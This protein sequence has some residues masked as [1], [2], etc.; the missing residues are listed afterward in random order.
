MDDYKKDDIF[1]PG[2]LTNSEYKLEKY[3][4]RG[5]YGTVWKCINI[6]SNNIYAI[7]I[8]EK[9]DNFEDM[10]VIYKELCLLFAMKNSDNIVSFEDY[11]IIENTIFIIFEY[12]KYDLYSI[13]NFSKLTIDLIVKI[14]YKI[15]Q[16]LDYLHNNNLIHRDIKP[17]NILIS[18]NYNNCKLCDFGLTILNYNNL[19]GHHVVTRW[20]RAPEIILKCN[21]DYAIDIWATGCILAE[22]LI[23]LI[24]YDNDKI[25]DEQNSSKFVLFPGEYDTLTS[26]NKYNEISHTLH[27]NKEQFSIIAELFG[28]DEINL[29]N[30]NSMNIPVEYHDLI[31]NLNIKKNICIEELFPISTKLGID[32]NILDLLKKMLIFNPHE[33]ITTKEALKHTV[34][35]DFKKEELLNYKLPDCEY[36]IKSIQEFHTYDEIKKEMINLHKLNK[37]YK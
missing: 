11:F 4:S 7:K 26:P 2:L 12:I 10:S 36:I 6:K 20:Y 35:K 15:L 22:L 17:Q 21:Y 37:I 16:S 8:I 3:I 29:D 25:F 31:N 13:S 33:R 32:S 30:L 18:E 14:L 5:S 1:G 19:K 34:F 23:N 27:S 28:T 24:N 9:I